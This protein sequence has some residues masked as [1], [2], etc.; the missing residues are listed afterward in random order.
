VLE[1][2][3]DHARDRMII[4][5]RIGLHLFD[6]DP[7]PEEGPVSEELVVAEIE[8]A[9]VASLLSM[10]LDN[11]SMDA[12][13]SAWRLTGAS[14]GPGVLEAV[15]IATEL[16]SAPRAALLARLFEAPNS[17][18]ERGCAA[19]LLSTDL[20]EYP[21]IALRSHALLLLYLSSVHFGIAAGRARVEEAIGR[22]WRQATMAPFRLH[23]PKITVPELETA[24]SGSLSA[25]LLAANDAVTPPLP[26]QLLAGLVALDS[27]KSQDVPQAEC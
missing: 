4:E 9:L 5:A 27:W 1:R 13:F 15:A 8:P 20:S 12:V 25:L 24:L 14:A 11:V 3:L 19:A 7:R 6:E 26:R 23:N 22:Y 21:A 17:E 18:F 10:S 2:V 16:A